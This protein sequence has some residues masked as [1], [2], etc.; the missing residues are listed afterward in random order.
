MEAQEVAAIDDHVDQQVDSDWA[1]RPDDIRQEPQGG[2]CGGGNAD[3][4]IVYKK[5]KK[6]ELIEW[7]EAGMPD[8]R[9]D[10]TGKEDYSWGDYDDTY[11]DF[12]NHRQHDQL[13]YNVIF[14]ILNWIFNAFSI[15]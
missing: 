5:Y 8:K 2:Y 11:C 3:T 14:D 12:L 15:N 4:G 6:S 1:Q 13:I 10:G 7:M 9:N